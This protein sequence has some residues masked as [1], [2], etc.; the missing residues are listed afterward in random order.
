VQQSCSG[1]YRLH[2]DLEV[3]AQRLLGDYRA[4]A[5]RLQS[6]YR[7]IAKRLQS[8]RGRLSSVLAALLHQFHGDFK[9]CSTCS[10]IMQLLRS[11][12]SVRLE[13]FCGGFRSDFVVAAERISLRSLSYSKRSQSD[14]K[15]MTER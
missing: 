14:R 1:S 10:A 9:F 11:D 5:K 12:F 7:A 13:R 8:D 2:C 4:I 6:D 3:F 15:A